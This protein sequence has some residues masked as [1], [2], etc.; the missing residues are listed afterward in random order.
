MD[1]VSQP[2][3]FRLRKVARYCQLYGWSRT[4]MKV[5]GQYHM[6]RKFQTPPRVDR[7][8]RE[9][10]TVGI[11]GCGNFAYSNI[12]YYLTRKRGRVIR[13]CMD[14]NLDRAASLCLDFRAGYYTDDF[15]R[16]AED[17]AIGLVYIASNHASHAEYAITALEHGK[18]VH[19]EKP[20]I[21]SH[22][23]LLRLCRAISMGRGNVNLG[24]NRPHSPLGAAI[25]RELSRE[26][27]P[28]V[29][30]WF[31]AG[32]EIP[33]DHWYFR[34]EEGGRVLGNLCH[35]ID[36]MLHM[37]PRERRYPIRIIPS[38]A[39]VSDCNIAVTYVFG[40]GS[41]GAITFS[42]MGHTFEGV[43]E[44]FA[45]HCG[46]LM[47]RLDDFHELI[48][49]RGA[50][51]SSLRS[52][53]RDHGHESAIL[54]SFDAARVSGQNDPAS[55]LA[56]VWESGELFL[57][58]KDALDNNRSMVVEAFSPRRLDAALEPALAS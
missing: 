25:R 46:D 42:S 23:Q 32:H 50:R 14:R 26:T 20:H 53:F 51:K 16:I 2:L 31:V 27:G 58:T 54:S 5:R 38:R 30:N 49:E 57:T 56:Y 18:S 40:D 1:Y 45:L 4:L 8:M 24:F 37:I 10:Q 28:V 47:I 36:F 11:V 39:N 35:W 7:S 9:T 48:V 6:K 55:A 52:L 29:M 33:A 17:P 15:S 3:F 19:I 44:R 21:V 43:R 13:G 34:A 22:D 41:I 12:A